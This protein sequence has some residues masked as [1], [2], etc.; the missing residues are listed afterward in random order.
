MIREHSL[1]DIWTTRSRT[2]RR[3]AS[4]ERSL[5]KAREAHQKALAM[6]AALE[7]EIEW[8]SYPLVRSQLEAQA[9]SRSRDCCRGRSR[10]Q[11]RRHC[12]VW[13]DDCHAPC[14]EYHT[15]QRSLESEGEAVATNDLNFE[16]PPELGLEVTYFLQG[17][18]ERFRRGECEGVLPQTPNRRVT[19]VGDL[20]GL[21]IQNHPAGG[22]S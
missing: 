2:P 11:K 7:E 3:V 22:K 17:L 13:L 21:S 4:V 18:A 5:T 1:A 6:A 20:E 14:F 12:Q 15:S 16:E 10:G 8:L 19:Q 9:H